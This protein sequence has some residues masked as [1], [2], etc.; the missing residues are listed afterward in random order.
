[1]PF[2]PK[3]CEIDMVYAGDRPSAEAAIPSRGAVRPDLPPVA[4]TGVS[5]VSAYPARPFS[6]RSD[7]AACRLRPAGRP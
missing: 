7:A 1:M 5:A 4:H 2:P 3:R 6:T